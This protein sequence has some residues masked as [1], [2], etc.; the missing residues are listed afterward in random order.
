[1]DKQIRSEG[2]RMIIKIFENKVQNLD[3]V[4]T[5]LYHDHGKIFLINE[6]PDLEKV[7]VHDQPLVSF[8]KNK[9][10][11]VETFN[12][13]QKSIDSITIK[14]IYHMGPFLYYQKKN[15]FVKNKD[16][17]RHFGIFVGG[18]RWH[19]LFLA[20]ILFQNHFLAFDVDQQDGC[21]DVM[22]LMQTNLCCRQKH[23]LYS[24]IEMMYMYGYL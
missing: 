13:V 5:H 19:R 16:I 8:L 20:S 23:T 18:S 10:I 15:L 24:Q 17:E 11:T 1:M 4:I 22:E 3:A 7:M 2:I 14:K 12:L 6:G 21:C 9:N